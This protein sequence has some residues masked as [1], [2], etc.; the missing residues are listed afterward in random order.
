[1]SDMRQHVQLRLDFGLTPTGEA[2]QG[3]AKGTESLRAVCAPESPAGTDRLMEEVCE[4]ANLQGAL[5]QVK[6]NKGS[7]GVDGMTVDALPSSW[8][9]HWPALR[10]RLR[11]GT[12][13]PMP[14]KRV[15]I[16]QPDGGM[17]QLGIPTGLDR[18][19]QQ[20]GMQVLQKRWDRTF[21][22]HSYGFRPGRSAQHAVAQA[23]KYIAE[24]YGGVADLD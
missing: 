24:G 15:E 10:E 8:K 1:M 2:R 4:R 21:S 23:Q 11:Q 17:R 18:C 7:A 22:E 14:V 9:Q 16:P 5:R 12:Y 20:A 6:T 19:I 13:E 3:R